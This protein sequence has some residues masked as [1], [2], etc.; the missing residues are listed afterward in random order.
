[1]DDSGKWTPPH[2][3]HRIG[4]AIDIRADSVN[5]KAG[6][7][8]IALFRNMQ[9]ISITSRGKIDVQIHCTDLSRPAGKQL[10]M[11]FSKGTKHP[12]NA[13]DNFKINRHFHVVFKK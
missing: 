4:D 8:P 3:S 5:Q 2:S 7:V 11:A 10:V 6:E 13:C 12:D 1:M 9:A